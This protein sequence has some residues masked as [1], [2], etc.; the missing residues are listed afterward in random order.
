VTGAT[1]IAAAIRTGRLRAAEATEAALVRAA[2]QEG[3]LDAFTTITAGRARAE[4]AA[5]DAAIARGRDP[6]PLGGVPYA[7]KNL[8]DLE[9]VA[10]IAGSIIGR[11]GPPASRDAFLV[12]RLSA[13]GGVCLGA[14][15]MDEYAFGFTTENSHYGPTRNPHDPARIA[16]GSSGGS[17][18]AVAAGVVPIALGSDTN[19]SIRVPASLCGVFGL[20]PTYGRLSRAGAFPFVG[21]LDHVGPL[22]RDLADLALAY[23]VLQGRDAEDPVQQD[24]PPEPVS[25]VLGAGLAGLRIAIA[26]GHFARG[27]HAEAFAAVAA[28]ARALD[29]TSTVEI[30]DAAR[31]RAAAVLITMAEAGNLHLPNLR[32]R[33][34]DFDPLIR[35]RLL[36]GALLPAHWLQQAQR[37]RAAFRAAMLRLF[38]EVDVILTPA[39]PH[40]ATP[41]GQD[42]LEVEG[43]TVPLRANLGLYTAPISFIGLPAM[44]VPIADPRA[45]GSPGGL[46]VG[47]QLIAAPWREDRLF[48]VA[49]ALE[50]AGVVASPEPPR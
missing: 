23:D 47:V 15:N 33:P 38:E 31:A 48:R 28:A 13:A 9:G 7:V 14:L 20:K 41:I 10:T 29:A 32:R 24:R 30:K 49:A 5:M 4:A 27:G 44:A 37:V 17:A 46:P 25:D 26:G 3:R 40:A 21:S 45:V 8:F 36:A 50:R 6:G 42:L 18:A 2:A 34:G 19:G 16:G 39:T 1:A 22:A 11:E 12:R 35:D 43:A